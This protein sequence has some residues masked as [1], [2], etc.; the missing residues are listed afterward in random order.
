MTARNGSEL[1]RLPIGEQLAA[2]T[3]LVLRNGYVGGVLEGVRR[4][5]LPNWYLTAGAVFQTVWNALSDTDSTAG[6]ADYDVFYFD[7]RDVGWDAEDAVI[8]TVARQF[9]DLPVDVEVRNEARVHVWYEQKFGAPCRPFSSTE[10]AIRAFASTTCSFGLRLDQHGRLVVY[11][12]YGFTDL[13]SFVLRPNP[14]LAPRE[15]YEAKAARWVGQW[16]Q[17]TVMPWPA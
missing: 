9:A 8:S 3:D 6:I 10:D 1:A 15:V 11:A 12:P 5:D 7:D 2:F 17:L 4:L 16:P 14:V 13:F